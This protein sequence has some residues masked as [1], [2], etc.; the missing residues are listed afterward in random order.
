MKTLVIAG[1]LVAPLATLLLVNSASAQ[2]WY[3]PSVFLPKTYVELEGGAT[4]EGRTKE[5]V[6]AYGLGATSQSASESDDLF[7]GALVGYKLTDMISVEGEGIYSRNHQAFVGDPILGS[8]GATRTYGGLANVKIGA[9]YATHV[10]GISIKPYVAGGVGYG[11]I[12][13]TGENGAFSYADRQ[14]GFLWQGK[15][16]VEIETGYHIGLDIAYRY[17]SSPRYDTPGSFSNTN[18]SALAQSHLQAVTAG[19]FYRF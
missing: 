2:T 3:D 16:G 5:Q 15:V 13:Y 1:T 19:I 12:Q 17:L 14:N 9:P 10:M 4:V 8:G 7:A 6:S 11:Q 18:Y